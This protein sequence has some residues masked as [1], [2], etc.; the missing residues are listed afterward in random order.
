MREFRI[1]T[2]SQGGW[3]LAE[4]PHPLPRCPLPPS[5]SPRPAARVL[6]LPPSRQRAAGGAPAAA[7]G[8]GAR[9]TIIRSIEQEVQEA[10]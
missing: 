3:P 9:V 10:A 4:P 5:P 6:D 7:R 8:N 2:C 1:R